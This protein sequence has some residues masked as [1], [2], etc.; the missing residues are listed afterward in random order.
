MK[1]RIPRVLTIRARLSGFQVINVLL[2][3]FRAVS[4]GSATRRAGL[5]PA[6]PAAGA[7]RA[8]GNDPPGARPGRAA[9]GAAA[10]SRAHCQAAGA[11]RAATASRDHPPAG[12]AAAGRAAAPRDAAAAAVAMPGRSRTAV[13]ATV[14][15]VPGRARR[16]AW[17]AGASRGTRRPARRRSPRRQPGRGGPPRATGTI[18][19][20]Y[21]RGLPLSAAGRDGRTG[22]RTD[23]P[24]RRPAPAGNRP[25]PSCSSR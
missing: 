5:R 4:R 18:P 21:G 23:D 19:W 10:A 11:A 6:Y 8:T 17:P 15:P 14:R 24:G 25:G 3:R 12:R 22:P 9:A 7:G 2:R 13:G 20:G 1:S 16:L